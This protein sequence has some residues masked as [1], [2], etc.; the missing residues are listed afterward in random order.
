MQKQCSKNCAILDRKGLEPTFMSVRKD[1]W[2]IF[3]NQVLRY[4][5][6]ISNYATYEALGT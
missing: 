2:I 4:N 1:A 3:S 5:A 6:H